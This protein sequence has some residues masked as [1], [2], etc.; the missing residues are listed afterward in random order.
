VL[1]AKG[2]PK[3]FF[4][5]LEPG[6]S[7]TFREAISYSDKRGGRSGLGSAYQIE[8]AGMYRVQAL[9]SLVPKEYFAPVSNG[10]TVPEHPLFSN[11][12]RFSVVK[13]VPGQTS[14]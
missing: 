14:R 4:V 5:I 1:A 3:D 2:Y 6:Q 10:A 8:R 7:V 9:F 13:K 11:W 12:A